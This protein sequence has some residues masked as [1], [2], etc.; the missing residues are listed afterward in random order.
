MILLI[1]NYDSFVYN[2]AR[3]V[4]ELGVET[5]VKRNDEIGLHEIK[6]LKPSHIIIS[7]GPCAPDQ[8]GV[9]MD[10]IQTFGA[11]KPILGVCLGHQAIGQIYG[12]IVGRAKNPMHGKASLIQHDKKNLFHGLE[13]PLT[14]A[15]YHSLIVNEENFPEQLRVTARCDR[16]EIMAIQHCEY[17]VYG[18]QF[19]PESVLTQSGHRLLKNFISLE[20]SGLC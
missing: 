1:D 3:Y 11:T 16:G 2:L 12:G 7:P 17:P 6:Q 18:V 5:L 13:N 8:A 20:T 15:R 19:H 10:V 4:S 14:V 9:S